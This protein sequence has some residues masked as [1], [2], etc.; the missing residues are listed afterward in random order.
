MALQTSIANT[1]DHAGDEA[2]LDRN[3]KK[4]FSSVNGSSRLSFC[5][6][7]DFVTAHANAIRGQN[8][9]PMRRFWLR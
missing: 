8:L 7:D 1:M 6:D 2:A 3:A 5:P 9:S 4:I